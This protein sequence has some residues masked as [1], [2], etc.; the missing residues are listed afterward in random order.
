MAVIIEDSRQKPDKNAHI[1]AQLEQLGHKVVRS[2][3]YVGDYQYAN[4]GSVVIDTKQDL[5]EVCSNVVQSHVRFRNE[6]LRAKE[7][8]VQLI[9]LIVDESISDLTGV[10]G[11]KNPR[12]FYSK[13]A[14][15]GRT[16]GKIMYKMRDEYGVRWEFATR[17]T[18]GQRL[19]ELLGGDTNAV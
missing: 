2:K 14:T 17:E 18:V 10:F 7:A 19:V 15:T 13:R 1:K 8:G 4:D 3:L 16:L 6:C 9:V 11:W 5:S 12:R